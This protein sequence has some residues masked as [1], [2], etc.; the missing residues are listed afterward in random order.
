MNR[1]DA[2]SILVASVFAALAVGVLLAAFGVTVWWFA[3]AAIL[4]WMIV[5]AQRW[6]YRLAVPVVAIIAAWSLLELLILLPAVRLPLLPSLLTVYSIGGVAG[7]LLLLGAPLPSARRVRASL[8]GWLPPLAGAILWS[9][10]CTIGSLR[11]AGA[12]FS[13]AMQGDSANNILFAREILAADGIR[14]GGNPVPVPAALIAVSAAPGRESASLAHDVGAFAMA[15]AILIAVL[16]WMVG[17]AATSLIPAGHPRAVTIVGVAGSLLPL[18][19]LVSGY[20]IELGFFNMQIA[21]VV[22]LMCWQVAVVADRAPRAAFAVQFF[23]A[24]LLLGVWSPLVLAPAALALAILVNQRMTV[25][26]RRGWR[27]VVLAIAVLQLILYGA[28]EVVPVLMAQGKLLV[29]SG[30]IYPFSR[31]TLVVIGILV[32]AGVVAWVRLRR[33]RIAMVVGA[34]FAGLGLAL[35]LLLFVSRNEPDPWTYYPLKLAWFVAIVALIVLGATAIAIAVHD[36]S[37][38]RW[39]RAAVIAV[40]AVS[41]VV[42]VL[43]PRAAGMSVSASP[44]VTMLGDGYFSGG[45]RDVADHIYAASDGKRPVV[46]W[47]S[48][49]PYETVS[50]F[51][52]MEMAAGLDPANFDLRVFAYGSYDVT[53]VHDLCTIRRLMGGPIEVISSRDLTT[54]VEQSCGSLAASIHLG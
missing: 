10:V 23:A 20:S 15:W 9:I 50:N 6:G 11:P 26:A 48:G 45:G 31:R 33:T 35:G 43:S 38:P 30:G 25:F 47:D 36:V 40:A 17:T 29:A 53:G 24:T 49:T 19:W 8:V 3:V 2:R 12:G 13:W 51:W 21:L 1:L 22:V 14:L 44:V 52:T 7:A 37:A 34:L 32:V 41:V 42:V 5:L 54:E 39:R 28:I 46:Y 18:T 4:P 16:C 27:L